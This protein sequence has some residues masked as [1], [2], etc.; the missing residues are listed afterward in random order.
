ME[1]LQYAF[2]E[3]FAQLGLPN[4]A[5]SIAQFLQTHRPLPGDVAL[6]DA[7]F[8]NPAQET[9]LRESLLEDNGWAQQVDA[10]SEALRGA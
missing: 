4:D 5:H 10:L 9:F 1:N 6:P 8:W 3:L 2:H 7:Y